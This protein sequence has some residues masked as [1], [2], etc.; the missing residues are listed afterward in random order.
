MLISIFFCYAREDKTLLDQLMAHLSP[1]QR[2]GLVSVWYDRDISAGAEWEPEIKAH[3]DTAQIVLLLIS[4]N[5]IAS[6]YAYGIEM[7]RALERHKRREAEVIPIILRPVH[8][9][10]KSLGGL[11][12]LPT[13]GKPVTSWPDLDAAFYDVVEGIQQVIRQLAARYGYQLPTISAEA[14]HNTKQ[15][16]TILPGIKQ[17]DTIP[18]EKSTI[19]GQNSPPT[20]SIPLLPISLASEKLRQQRVLSGHSDSIWCLALS[21]DGQ[22]LVSGSA[23]GTMKVWNVATARVVQT[24]TGHTQPVLS[25]ALSANGQRLASG[26]ADRTVKVWDLSNSQEVYSFVAHTDNVRG[27]ALSANGRILVSGSRDRTIK[28]WDLSTGLEIG[29]LTGHTD[30]VTSV[31]ISSDGRLLVSGSF[32]QTIKVWDLPTGR[33]RCA[34]TGHTGPVWSVALSSDKQCVVSG[35]ADGTIKIWNASTGQEVR[36]LE[37]HTDY[38]FCV[39]LSKNG[40][41][42][43]SGSQDRTIR[44][45]KLPTGQEMYTLTDHTDAIWCLALSDDGR[46]LA[47]GGENKTIKL[48]GV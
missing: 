41:T 23:D 15:A 20:F 42:L 46:I 27:I 43:V 37:N 24:L 25:I 4:P 40:Q 30:D 22:T 8:W 45:W 31:V 12:A 2:E 3:L 11:Q 29:T 6:D 13:D 18:T 7:Q 26:S 14:L 33:E 19:I 10:G 36:T 1:L 16:E 21:A 32:D 17:G 35:S 48:W 5:F 44:V 34:L 38:I 28:V 9:R 47:S 39:A